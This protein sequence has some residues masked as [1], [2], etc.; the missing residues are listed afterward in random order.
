MVHKAKNPPSW[1][2]PDDVGVAAAET[3][4][5]LDVE[6]ATLATWRTKGRGPK[7]RKVGRRVE[8]TPRFIREYQ[9]SC[10][11]APEPAST[12]RQRCVTTLDRTVRKSVAP[13]E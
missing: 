9:E 1:L 4:V 10:V 8:Y 3:A 7:Y 6:E 13:A 11:R 12:R 5:I 2:D